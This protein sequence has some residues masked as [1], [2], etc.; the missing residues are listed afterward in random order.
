VGNGCQGLT[1]LG[2][3]CAI[4]IG[5]RSQEDMNGHPAQPRLPQ[6][7]QNGRI[8]DE[9]GVEVNPVRA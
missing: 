1:F 6:C 3:R 9:V 8:V 5:I 2:N 4:V 7:R